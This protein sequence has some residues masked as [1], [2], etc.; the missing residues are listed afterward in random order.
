MIPLCLKKSV[1]RSLSGQWCKWC[2]SQSSCSSGRPVDRVRAVKHF[3]FTLMHT[4]LLLGLLHG[5]LN[6]PMSGSGFVAHPQ[7]GEKTR[8]PTLVCTFAWSTPCMQQFDFTQA[9][10]LLWAFPFAYD[11]I[12]ET[13]CIMNKKKWF[14][15]PWTHKTPKGEK[16]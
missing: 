8:D 9:H 2:C 13:Q 4:N 14:Q 6:L 12:P 5:M 1:L 15:N 10:M 16:A 3:I 7:R 11:Y